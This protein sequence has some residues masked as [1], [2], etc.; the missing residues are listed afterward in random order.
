MRFKQI[1]GDPWTHFQH[2]YGIESVPWILYEK[3][4]NK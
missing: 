2:L 1:D 3:R 4:L